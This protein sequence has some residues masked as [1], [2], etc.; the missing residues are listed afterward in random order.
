MANF[1]DFVQHGNIK[2]FDFGL[3]REFKPRQI[4]KYGTY[5]YTALVG[6]PRYMAPEVAN[7]LL[8]NESCDI[9]SFTLLLWEVLSLQQPFQ[10]LSP[11]SMREQ[12]WA[13]PQTRPR[14]DST[15]C[16]LSLQDLVKLGWSADASDRP[17]MNIVS[18][19]LGSVYSTMMHH[20][21][22]ETK[23]EEDLLQLSFTNPVGLSLPFPTKKCLLAL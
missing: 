13:G 5:Q 11:C 17:T 21:E 2:L 14:L 20:V 23:Q 16:P 3:A 18:L 9:Y 19:I 7:R 6:S 4:D 8:Y 10:Q 15:T 22:E 1:V 12:V